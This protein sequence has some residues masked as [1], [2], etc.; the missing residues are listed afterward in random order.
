[1]IMSP[2]LDLGLDLNALDNQPTTGDSRSAKVDPEH[3]RQIE[4][5]F[6]VWNH[7][8]GGSVRAVL[9]DKRRKLIGAALDLYDLQTVLDA[10]V[11]WRFSP[12]H[13]GNNDRGKKY[14]SI[15]LM[16]RNSDCIE[17]FATY[18][19]DAGFT[20]P[21]SLDGLDKSEGKLGSPSPE[22]GVFQYSGEW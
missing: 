17:R 11:G 20:T 21:T 16:L 12:H 6:G 13:S 15:E 14:N 1:M 3:Q 8:C 18:T 7:Y 5:V 10:V 22:L 19:R 2:L 4:L 9:S